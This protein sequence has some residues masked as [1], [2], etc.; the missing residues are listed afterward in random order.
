MPVFRPVSLYFSWI[1]FQPMTIKVWVT[2]VTQSISERDWFSNQYWLIQNVHV[3]WP[4]FVRYLE[5][6]P[7]ISFGVDN[8]CHERFSLD[9]LV[10]PFIIH[11]CQAF[12]TLQLEVI[13]TVSSPPDPA[14][15][16]CVYALGFRVTKNTCI[17]L[18]YVNSHLSCVSVYLSNRILLLRRIWL[19]QENFLNLEL[20]NEFKPKGVTT[21]MK[22]LGEDF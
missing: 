13:S 5:C 18:V 12:L 14:V 11:F 7:R 6:E 22:A 3:S 9:K 4:I 19:N 20:S 21:Q 2:Q 8:C 16:S 10:H 1:Q 17:K 15:S